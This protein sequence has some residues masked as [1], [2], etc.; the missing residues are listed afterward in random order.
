M[1]RGEIYG[2]LIESGSSTELHV[3]NSISD[4]SPLDIAGNFEK[5]AEASGE[6]IT[7]KAYAP[8]PLAPKDPF[9]LVP[10]T[11]LIALLVGGY[12]SASLLTSTLGS[13]SDG[14]GACG[15]PGSRS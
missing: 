12:M 9:A 4:V 5:A 7:V 3:V 14:G 6:K 1:D 15:W 11:L 13:A 10:S 2:A 8:T